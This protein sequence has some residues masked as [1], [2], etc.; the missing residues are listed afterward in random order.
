MTQQNCIL[1]GTTPYEEHPVY[2]VL[3]AYSQRGKGG[4]GGVAVWVV[5]CWIAVKIIIHQATLPMLVTEVVSVSYKR[6]QGN[7]KLRNWFA[8]LTP[9]LY[10]WVRRCINR[11]LAENE[12]KLTKDTWKIIACIIND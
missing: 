1:K 2:R 9:S 8:H 11:A 12:I 6:W 5:C 10:A 7:C 3:Q 4:G